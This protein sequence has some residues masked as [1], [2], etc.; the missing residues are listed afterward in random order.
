[1]NVSIKD[2]QVAMEI[3]NRGIELAVRDTDGTHRG[4][5]VVTKTRVIW[6]RGRTTR[7]NGHSLTWSQFIALMQQ[8]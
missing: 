7:A 8:Q 5:L 3:K 6:C 2:F 1:M 4:D